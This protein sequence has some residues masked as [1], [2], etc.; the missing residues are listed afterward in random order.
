MKMMLALAASAKKY[1]PGGLMIRLA[2][3][4]P[5]LRDLGNRLLRLPIIPRGNFVPKLPKFDN[6]L[7]VYAQQ[8]KFALYYGYRIY[9]TEDNKDQLEPLLMCVDDKGR[10]VE[11]EKNRLDSTFYYVGIRIPADDIQ[12]RRYAN[13]F[14]RMDYL[15]D[16]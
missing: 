4:Y 1:L 16:H 10:V 11:P 14:N 13:K 8:N 6:D 5:D 7:I 2:R 12:S 3:N 15:K 9:K